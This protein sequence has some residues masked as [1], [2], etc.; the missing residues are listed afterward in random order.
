MS[1][2]Q[3]FAGLL[4]FYYIRYKR[5]RGWQ[6]ESLATPFPIYTRYL[7]TE[8]RC[9]QPLSHVFTP[10]QS[11]TPHSQ[12]PLHQ[13]AH[14]QSQAPSRQNPQQ[15]FSYRSFGAQAPRA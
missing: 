9:Q 14:H 11:Q 8:S 7:I 15:A 3:K 13:E 5:K 2:L 4:K 10:H 6:A 12:A 1:K